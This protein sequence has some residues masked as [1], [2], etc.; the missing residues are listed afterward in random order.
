MI[1]STEA[2]AGLRAEA[3]VLL[4]VDGAPDDLRLVARALE[5]RFGAD[6]RVWA[7]A[8]PAEGL[9]VLAGVLQVDGQQ[10]G[11]DLK[12]GRHESRSPPARPRR[13]P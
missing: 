4:V 5:R 9:E 11:R 8:T 10:L 2:R 1:T 12:V 6:Y 13:W 7:A 3:P